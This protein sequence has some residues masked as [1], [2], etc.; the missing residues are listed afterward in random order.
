MIHIKR[1][2]SEVMHSTSINPA[3]ENIANN[4]FKNKKKTKK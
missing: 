1:D 4:L 2:L 3:L